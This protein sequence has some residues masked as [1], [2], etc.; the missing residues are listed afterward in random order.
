MSRR[1]LL[2]R[3]APEWRGAFSAFVESGESSDAFLRYLDHSQEAQEAVEIAFREQAAAFDEAV[4]ALR[5]GKLGA[6][7]G[8]EIAATFAAALK[9]T[10]ALSPAEQDGVLRV[11]AAAVEKTEDPE[12]LKAVV[13]KLERSLKPA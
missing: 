7:Q 13:D 1:A 9:E 6:S 4:K 12:K 10:L 5:G 2:E 3:V 11:A 8:V